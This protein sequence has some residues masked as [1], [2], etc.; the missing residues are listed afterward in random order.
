[1]TTDKLSNDA[2]L[3]H[4]DHVRRCIER[5]WFK[6]SR[7]GEQPWIEDAPGERHCLVTP[8]GRSVVARKDAMLVMRGVALSKGY[9]SAIDF[10]NT[11]ET[12]KQDVFDFLD[13][14]KRVRIA[15]ILGAGVS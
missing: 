13:E 4:F 3:Q 5:R 8:V 2:M 1:M 10:N 9:T 15:A 14:C 12:T 6:G 7:N 11:P